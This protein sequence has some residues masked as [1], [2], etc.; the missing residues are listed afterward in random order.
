MLSYDEES[1]LSGVL[2]VTID[3]KKMKVRG[4]GIDEAAKLLSGLD[5]FSRHKILKQMQGLDPAMTSPYQLH[6]FGS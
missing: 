4:G 3:K 6:Q 2:M 5:E 1:F